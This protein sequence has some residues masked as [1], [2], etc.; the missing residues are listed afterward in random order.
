M[1]RWEDPSAH[2]DRIDLSAHDGRFAAIRHDPDSRQLWVAT[3]RFGTLP[4]Y[5]AVGPDGTTS[6][7]TEAASVA[8]AAGRPIRL[9]TRGA[10]QHL[11]FGYIP[12]CRTLIDGVRHVPVGTW[13]EAGSG[14]EVAY[15]RRRSTGAVRPRD[16]FARL[17]GL[18]DEAVDAA[19]AAAPS[20]TTLLLSGGW[21]SRAL[22]VRLLER[23]VP[24]RA[25][26]FGKPDTPDVELAVRLARLAGLEHE[27][28]QFPLDIDGLRG[29]ARLNA[30]LNDYTYAALSAG[31]SQY[32]SIDGALWNGTDNF[33]GALRAGQPPEE[34]LFGALSHRGLPP[35]LLEAFGADPHEVGQA[36]AEIEDLARVGPDER[37][38]DAF[39]RITLEH[40]H[41]RWNTSRWLIDRCTPMITPWLSTDLTEF[42]H[43]LPARHRQAKRAYTLANRRRYPLFRSVPVASG[44]YVDGP[45]RD[46]LTNPEL[47]SLMVAEIEA[48]DEVASLIDPAIFA[49]ADDVG[50]SDQYFLSL[51]VVRLFMLALT[52][53]TVR[54]GVSATAGVHHP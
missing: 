24:L 13:L 16:A 49:K 52:L 2:R 21:D 14:T 22:L 46:V 7:G 54:D 51:V 35:E 27:V 4:L 43:S 33:S 5:R 30:D 19:L 44:G 10:Y 47:R 31:P 34:I 3:D 28:R 26:T 38:D 8:V 36:F 50:W 12:G 17:L 41:R 20:P 37:I 29:W 23:D 53:S 39:D 45:Y 11:C 9:D 42:Y 1:P 32:G 18:Q 48:C 40:S 25:L 6:V 15:W